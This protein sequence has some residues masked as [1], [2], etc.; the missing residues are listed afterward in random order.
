[1]IAFRASVFALFACLPAARAGDSPT[2]KLG[3]A[4]STDA[5]VVEIS[6]LD[7]T[8]LASLAGAKLSEEEW[9]KVARLVVDTEAAD[10]ATRPG[11]A[12]AWSV[13]ADG[14]R[15]EP[16]FPLV[17]GVNY[18]AICHLKAAPR[19]K[20][21]SASFT[22]P[23]SIPKPPPGPRVRVAAVYP[24]ANR[25]PENTLR[26]YIQFTGPVERGSVYKYLKLNRADG[27]AVKRPFLEIDQELWSEDGRR[28]TVLFDPG[29]VK[30]GLAPREEDGP[31]LE[32][33]GRFT[34]T[35]DPA[36]PDQDG[37]PLAVPHTKTFDVLAPDDEPVWPDDW[38]VVA[39]RAGSD[40]PVTVRL[41]KPL[42]RALL[43]RM[44]W[45]ADAGGKPVAG[46]LSVGGGERV[47]AFAP[48][49]PWRKGTYKLLVDPRL[50]DACGNRVGE[51]F[52]LDS[53]KLPSPRPVATLAERPFVV[54]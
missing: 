8:D 26:L 38:A 9:A 45:V 29:R 40:S 44:L 51:P 28:L 33:G 36:W 11:V 4:K 41:A 34:F 22:L 39:P 49:E 1:M 14:L 32:E 16:Q 20:I 7:K 15:F 35:I 50:E 47:V 31:I 54:K 46:T 18:R 17:P 27:T 42:D 19:T 43:A 30:R 5:P 2:I 23:L 12:G 21:N 48:K 3:A 24:S 53:R 52:E 25:L 13:G 37:R 6:G 10:L